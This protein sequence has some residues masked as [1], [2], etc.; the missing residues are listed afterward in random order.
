MDLLKKTKR[1]ET[2]EPP[3]TVKTMMEL[4]KECVPNYENMGFA[5]SLEYY[6][7]LKDLRVR[8]DKCCV[9]CQSKHQGKGKEDDKP[10]VEEEYL[11]MGP[12]CERTNPVPPYL[13]MKPVDKCSCP[14]EQYKEPVS[15]QAQSATPSP[16]LRR[17]DPT[18]CYATNERRR[19]AQIRRRSNSMDS[20]RYCVQYS[21]FIL[22]QKSSITQWFMS[23]GGGPSFFPM[24]AA[25]S[26]GNRAI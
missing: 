5:Q 9:K 14:A 7:N 16:C 19:M 26:G 3:E 20:G 10:K 25:A 1:K 24:G 6:E 18:S 13:H 12:V 11:V 4:V 17:H 22:F 8:V 2:T 23:I 15:T 21:F